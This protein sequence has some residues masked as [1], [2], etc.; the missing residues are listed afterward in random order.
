MRFPERMP[1]SIRWRTALS[2]VGLAMLAALAITLSV[3]PARATD[4]PMPTDLE[5][6]RASTGLKVSWSPPDTSESSYTLV[7]Y[8]IQRKDFVSSEYITLVEHTGDTETSYIDSS[9]DPDEEDKFIG[10][11]AYGYRLRAIYEDADET[12][13][14]SDWTTHVVVH[15]PRY[16]KPTNLAVADTSE[17]D[18]PATYELTWTAPTLSWSEDA[19]ALSGYKVTVVGEIPQLV[20]HLDSDVTSYLHNPSEEREYIYQVAAHFGVFESA[21]AYYPPFGQ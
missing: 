4:T 6:G 12:L 3:A 1:A 7:G 16:P 19:A 13:H 11:R 2:S 5:G 21:Q 14:Y 8:G 9:G 10:G 20:V 18:E 17:E 15:V